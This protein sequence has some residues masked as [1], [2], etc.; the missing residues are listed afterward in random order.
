MIAAIVVTLAQISATPNPN[1]LPGKSVVERIVDG[2]FF[3]TLLA[4]L[5]GVFVSVLVWVLSARAQ[6]YN[7]AS[8]GRQGTFIALGGALVTGAGPALI[9]FFQGLGSQVH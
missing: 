5:A 3:Y 4:C 1:G 8:M 7:H 9:N 6:N 2:L